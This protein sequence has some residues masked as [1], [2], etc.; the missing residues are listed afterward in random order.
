MQV[1]RVKEPS[2]SQHLPQTV[3]A[4]SVTGG[5][6]GVGKSSIALNLAM[7]LIATGKKVM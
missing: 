2:G 6:G 5:K 4:I 7:S 1:K 3:R